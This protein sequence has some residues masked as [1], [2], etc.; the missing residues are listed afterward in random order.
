MRIDMIMAYTPQA[1]G[2][3]KRSNQALQD[4]LVKE[5]RLRGIA[6]MADA[7]AHVPE[8]MEI[9]NRRY[10]KEATD[11]ASAHRP[12]TGSDADLDAALA[13]RGERT[14]SKALTF[15]ADGVL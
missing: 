10:G 12:W 15:S 3:V 6:T 2:W 14:L 7:Q 4:G 1:K 13:R 5:M 11:F 8:F 9:W